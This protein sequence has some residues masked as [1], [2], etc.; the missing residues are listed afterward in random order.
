MI[1]S[2]ADILVDVFIGI[3]S[4]YTIM[5]ASY[6]LFWKRDRPTPRAVSILLV[7]LLASSGIYLF[8]TASEVVSGITGFVRVWDAYNLLQG[9]ANLIAVQ[10]VTRLICQNVKDDHEEIIKKLPLS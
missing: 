1:L 7:F 9:V 5:Y 3:F 4:I 8:Q 10:V 6:S 2:H